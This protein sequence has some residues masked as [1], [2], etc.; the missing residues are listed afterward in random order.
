[1]SRHKRF[2]VHPAN[3]TPGFRK[4]MGKMPIGMRRLIAVWNVG[5][6]FGNGEELGLLFFKLRLP[7]PELYRNEGAVR[8]DGGNQ[9]AGGFAVCCGGGVF[10]EEQPLLF[11]GFR[12]GSKGTKGGCGILFHGNCG[13]V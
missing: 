7:A 4:N 8:F 9:I 13:G 12:G 5:D 3:K 6:G 11:V 10:R 2:F 1:M